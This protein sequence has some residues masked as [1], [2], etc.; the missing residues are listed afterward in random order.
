MKNK[1]LWLL[2]AVI[3]FDF[4][5]TLLGQPPSF[6]QHPDTANEGNPVFRWFMVRGVAVYLAF[7]F[8]YV[9]GVVA[10]VSRLPRQAAIII[11]LVFLLSHY[12]AGSTWL[13]F[14]F[15]LNMMGP[16]IY[17]LALA[18]ALILIFNSFDWRACFGNSKLE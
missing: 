2:A 16:A 17:A 12:F 5:I 10:L 1:L 9:S 15:R 11:G 8:G 13:D 3:V 18:I 14:H 6:W 4:G 7:I